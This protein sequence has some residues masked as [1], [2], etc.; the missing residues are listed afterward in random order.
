MTQRD[1][2]GRCLRCGDTARMKDGSC[3][4]CNWKGYTGNGKELKEII[5]KHKEGINGNESRKQ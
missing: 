4:Y 1:E 3:F 5:K 2:M